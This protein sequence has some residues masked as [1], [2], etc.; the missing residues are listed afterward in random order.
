[1]NEVKVF[2]TPANLQQ[3][4]A[5]LTSLGKHYEAIGQ[6]TAGNLDNDTKIIRLVGVE[7][8]ILGLAQDALRLHALVHGPDAAGTTADGILTE[9]DGVGEG[10]S[11]AAGTNTTVEG[12]I[13]A[14]EGLRGRGTPIIPILAK[15]P[16]ELAKDGK[17][18][19]DPAAQAEADKA[20][21]LAAKAAE[22]AA[23]SAAAASGG[24]KS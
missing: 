12:T 18:P 7:G 11:E 3:S 15:G 19:L 5:L 8:D 24:G 17:A 2:V 9:L 4:H 21:A 6:A 20:A 22:E 13:K 10:V 14:T 16:G 23:A 1:M